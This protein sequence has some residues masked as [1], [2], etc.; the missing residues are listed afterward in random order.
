MAIQALYIEQAGKRIEATVAT[1]QF[2]AFL[3]DLA[4]R[5]KARTSASA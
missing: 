1:K 4:G 5:F 3:R 2:I